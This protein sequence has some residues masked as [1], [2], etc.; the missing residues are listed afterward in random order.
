MAVLAIFLISIP[1][2]FATDIPDGV[3]PIIVVKYLGATPITN[4]I[5]SANPNA[6][7]GILTSE[8]DLVLKFVTFPYQL[9]GT[10]TTVNKYRCDFQKQY[11]G[12]WINATRNGQEVQTN[13]PIWISPPPYLVLVS[14]VYDAKKNT[15]TITL[16]ENPR[17]AVAL[18]LS[19]YVDMQ[20]IG[21]ATTGTKE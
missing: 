1:L 5:N 19:R 9:P 16:R 10:N 3:E 7:A 12:F 18:V 21:K 14:E 20:P 11:C 15:L 8:S 17:D 4:M 13:S 6:T 2:V